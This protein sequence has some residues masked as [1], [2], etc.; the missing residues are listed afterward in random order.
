MCWF[1]RHRQCLLRL[2]LAVWVLAVAV[3]AVQGCLVQ[4]SHDIAAPHHAG[5]SVADAHALHATGCLQGC[6]DVATAIKP[7]VQI[8]ALVPMHWVALLLLTAAVSMLL[9]PQRTASFAA[10]ALKRPS[11]PEK[12]V[13]LTFVRFND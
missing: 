7:A 11:P 9:D 12:P 3:M 13:R 6:E 2:S 10:L 5:Q 8:P 4:P 1:R